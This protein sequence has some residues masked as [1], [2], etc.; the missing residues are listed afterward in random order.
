MDY[1]Q[2]YL[3]YKQKYLNLLRVQK[4]GEPFLTDIIAGLVFSYLFERNQR[5][6][7]LILT[8]RSP[9]M[10]QPFGNFTLNP[11]YR[12]EILSRSGLSIVLATRLVQSDRR[13]GFELQLA[14][15]ILSKTHKPPKISPPTLVATLDERNPEWHSYIVWSVAFH[16]SL[17]LLVTVSGDRTAKLW[18]LDNP[19]GSVVTLVANLENDMGIS[20]VAFHPILPLLVT[21]YNNTKLWHLDNPTGTAATCVAILENLIKYN[22]VMCVAFHPSLP[23][24]ATGSRDHSLQLWRLDKSD[25]SEVTFLATLMEHSD[26]V[27]SV[28]FHTRLPLMVTG[29]LDHTVKLWRLDPNSL[30]ATCV[31]T[32]NR[33]N[34][35]HSDQVTSVAFHPSLPLLATGSEDCT[36]KLWR[37]DPDGSSATC[38]VTLNEGNGGHINRVSSVAFHQTLPLFATGSWDTTTKIWRLDKPDGSVATCVATLDNRSVH[39]VAF[40]PTLPL[41]AVCSDDSINL[42]NLLDRSGRVQIARVSNTLERWQTR[43]YA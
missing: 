32:L 11:K 12:L 39:S 41:L 22:R 25:G 27:S 15:R 17:P 4:G 30:I 20:S 3:K 8:G 19:D 34:G 38:V 13:N 10:V 33:E 36:M 43:Y 14:K 40:H 23:L 5:Q 16:P 29:S 6:L 31:A 26:E 35:G 1:K 2:K 7:Q 21:G 18:R 9:V 42:W 37:L 28:A 24:L